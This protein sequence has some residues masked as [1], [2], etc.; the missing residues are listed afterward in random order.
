MAPQQRLQILVQHIAGEQ[1]PRV[2]STRLNSHT[3]RV[4]PGVAIA[5]VMAMIGSLLTALVMAREYERGTIEGLLAT[6]ISVPA[7]VLN[8]VLPYF[9]LGLGSTGLCVA[10]AVLG[11]GL[12]FRGSVLALFAIGASFL[13]AVLGQG[14]MISAATKNQFVSTQFALLSGFLPSLLLSG[15]LFEIDSMPRPIQWLTYIVPART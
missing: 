12:P 1:E 2:A 9:I 10:V 8:K 11:Y 5:I 13:V 15:F 4:V 7:L 6:P 3:I 14:L